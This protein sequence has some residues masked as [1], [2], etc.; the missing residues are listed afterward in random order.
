MKIPRLPNILKNGGLKDK[1][2]GVL[3]LSLQVTVNFAL[4]ELIPGPN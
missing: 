1:R 4:K 3:L 2:T